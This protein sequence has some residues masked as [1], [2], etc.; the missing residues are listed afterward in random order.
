MAEEKYDVTG[1][2]CAAC[3]SHV[4]KAVAKVPGV[5]SVEVSLLTNSMVVRGDATEADVIA[6]VESGGYGA[7]PHEEQT[8]TEGRAD[9]EAASLKKRLI[10]SLIFLLPLF[11][12]SMGHMMGLPVPSFFMGAE[13]S[14]RLALVELALTIPIVI[15]NRK[16]YTNG[17]KAMLHGAPNMDSLIAV[18]S[19]AALGYGLFAT[20]EIAAALSQGDTHTAHGWMMNLYLESA[21]MILS[22]ITVGKYL[23]ARSKG[24]TSE[25]ITR[26]I[27]LAP[28]T[29]TVVR[30][31]AE[32]EVP[33]SEV[34]AGDIVTVRP[35]GRIPV[36]GVVTE[37]GTAVDES[38][39]TGESVPAEKAPGDRVLAASINRT[40]Y[41]RFRAERV[42]AD[43]SFAKI[44]RLVEEASSSKAPIARLADKVAGV[45][46]P[47]VIG[48]A[49]VTV[50]VWLLSGAEFAFALTCG[51]SVLVISCPCALGL[52]TPVAIMVGTGRGAEQGILIKSAEALERAH[53]VNTMVFDKTGT[54]TEGAPK[55]TDV[56]AGPGMTEE[57]LLSIA[58]SLEHGSEHPLAEAVI[59]RAKERDIA[60]ENAENFLSLPGMGV[61]AE[62]GGR[63]FF[64]GNRRLAQERGALSTEWAESAEKL[65][66]EGKTP[67]YIGAE[68]RILG[69]IAAADPVRESSRPALAALKAMGIETVML[70]GD[71]MLTAEAVRG[72]LGMARAIAEVLPEDK[73]REVAALQSS[74]RTTAMVGDGINDAPA[75]ARADVGIAIGAG[76]DVAIDSADIVLMHSDP[77][78]AARAVKLSRAVMR[79]I[80]ENLFWAFFYNIIGIPIAAGLFYPIWGW[81]L[82]PMFASAAMSL[83]SVCVVSNALRLRGLRLD[84]PET[85]KETEKEEKKKMTKKVMVEGMMC[86]HCVAHVAKALGSLSGVEKV[87]VDLKGGF[88]A[89]E[90]STDVP[91]EK[92]RAA[93][94]EAGYK[95]GAII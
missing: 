23:E 57:E 15:I 19:A 46:V 66:A 7:A 43:T 42:G 50:A 59:E 78:D 58:A 82:T 4:E 31:G 41:I 80:K 91:D 5:D 49:A 85:D 76:A 26:L 64:A 8:P 13:N 22:L 20:V 17:F 53:S 24:R 86:N 94:D 77:A 54:L 48:I 16:Y 75:L 92:I 47:V 9:P 32:M 28:Q 11:Y 25:A 35:G 65:A 29:A 10:Y 70:T 51:I 14:L 6:A 72:R 63:R 90:L 33:V 62:V 2:S 61:E 30:N 69:I 95:A 18:G 21:G 81:Q 45:F 52:A 93:I 34:A 60:P 40:G 74:G 37:G 36:D 83:S 55:V 3:A 12:L 1:M 79:N 38:A 88:A 39:L 73:E 89:L 27:K 87:D 68:G 44:I 84:M 67:L 71:N 56:T